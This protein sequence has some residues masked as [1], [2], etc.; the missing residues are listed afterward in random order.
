[1]RLQFIDDCRHWWKLNSNQ[2][3][4]F[5]ALLGGVIVAMWPVAQWALNEILPRDPLWRIPFAAATV[6]VTFGSFLYARLRSQP[7]LA[8]PKAAKEPR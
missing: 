5:W 6:A 7:K 8:P 3:A 2:V 4:A 1:M